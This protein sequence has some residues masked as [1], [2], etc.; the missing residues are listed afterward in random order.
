MLTFLRIFAGSEILLWQY[1]QYGGSCH[2]FPTRF[3]VVDMLHSPCCLSI[4][5]LPGTFCASAP[6]Q[7]WGR[8]SITEGVTNPFQVRLSLTH[9]LCNCELPAGECRPGSLCFSQLLF[10]V[11]FR[12]MVPHVAQYW[13]AFMSHNKL[14]TSLAKRSHFLL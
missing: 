9:C 14:P 5:P 10:P 13:G 2:S 12:L 7:Q 8:S 1:W 6:S 11:S 4:L 3:V